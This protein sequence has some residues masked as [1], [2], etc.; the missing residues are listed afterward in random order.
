MTA[1]DP[2]NRK[3]LT[4]E[5][6]DAL[7][8]SASE[9]LLL[10][11]QANTDPT[12]VLTELLATPADRQDSRAAPEPAGPAGKLNRPVHHQHPQSHRRSWRTIGAAVFGAC[13]VIVTSSIIASLP[14]RGPKE[15][16]DM[17]PPIPGP[18]RVSPSVPGTGHL[19]PLC[20]L[21]SPSSPPLIRPSPYRSRTAT[22]SILFSVGQSKLDGSAE[23]SL[24]GLLQ[25][26]GPYTIVAITIIGYADDASHSTRADRLSRARAQA[27]RDWLIAHHIPSCEL[28][29]ASH[30]APEARSRGNAYIRHSAVITVR[31]TNPVRAAPIVAPTALCD[32]LANSPI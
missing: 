29:A 7:L 3:Q 21:P 2:A 27:V 12:A 4:D 16:E 13:A 30:G 24:R 22:D 6:L 20:I 31:Y 14:V 10:H 19:A 18:V 17:P 11:I 28:H 26:I 32:L 23:C 15:V 1:S 9:E 8:E 25:R 5:E